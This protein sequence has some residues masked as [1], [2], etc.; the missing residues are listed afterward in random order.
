MKQH[1]L[2]TQ[3]FSLVELAVVLVIMGIVLTM[4]LKA[5]MSMLENT[6]YS[7]TQAKQAQLKVSL[8][9]FLRTNGRLPCPDNTSAIATGIEAS[10]C[11]DGYG[12]IPWQALGISRDM[13]TDGWGNLFTYR[14][15]NGVP[16]GSKNWT[17]KVIV[18]SDF[19]VNEFKTSTP[20]LTFK[21][22]DASGSTLLANNTAVAVIISHGKNGYGAK[23]TKVD[24]R[25]SATDAG[26]DE[27]SNANSTTTTFI[28]RPSSDS[29]PYDDLLVFMTPQDLLQP[30]VSEGSLKSCQAYCS[31][32]ITSTCTAPG[33]CA[34]STAGVPGVSDIIDPCT[35]SC[36]TCIMTP[37]LLTCSP[38]VAPPVGVKPASCV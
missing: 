15:A 34:C 6:A 29:L 18:G 13:A 14:V 22:L 5:T 1:T 16:A 28:L 10:P 37:I 24:V 26:G 19:S 25:I 35:G 4:G 27:A 11:T 12:V 20:A 23:T 32:P 30:L 9:S 17:S 3:G 33:I 38:V 36:G 31:P 8:I 2:K 7:N 21:E